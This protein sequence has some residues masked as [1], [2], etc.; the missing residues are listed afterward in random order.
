[1]AGESLSLHN[2]RKFSTIKDVDNDNFSSRN[3]AQYHHGAWWFKNCLRAHLNGEY[4]GGHHNLTYQ[5]IVWRDF[6]GFDYSQSH[7][8]ES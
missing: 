4:F 5:G 6:K 8:I 2:G 1:M 3:C 7:R